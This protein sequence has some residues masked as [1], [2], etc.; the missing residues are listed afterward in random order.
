MPS[1]DVWDVAKERLPGWVYAAV[2]QKAR[3]LNASVIVEKLSDGDMSDGA[4][5]KLTDD[6]LAS[7][8]IRLNQRHVRRRQRGASADGLLGPASRIVDELKRRGVKMNGGL[9]IVTACQGYSRDKEK[10]FKAVPSKDTDTSDKREAQRVRAKKYGISIQESGS[11]LSYPAGSPTVESLYGD[12][13]NLRYPLGREDNRPDLG[14]L[15]N[16]LARF[17]Q[18]GIEGYTDS[19]S[20]AIVFE[21]IVRAALTEGVNV[22]YSPDDPIDALLP[23]GLVSQLV[24]KSKEGPAYVRISKAMPLKRIV[25]GVVLDPYGPNGAK[26]DA[27]NDYISPATIEE[28]AHAF[29]RGQRTIG[30]QHASEADAVLIESSIEQ[31]PPGEYVRAMKGLSHKVYRRPFGDDIVHSGSWIV[32]VQLG[33]KEWDAFEKNE[34]NA[35]SPGG[36][37]I[38]RPITEDEMPEVEFIDLVNGR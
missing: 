31:Y 25:Y 21:R 28:T 5:E 6:E 16:A 27:H 7:S 34:I 20:R 15:R 17:K 19:A 1:K 29:M 23:A 14:R 36:L 32:G 33:E 38:R 4:I 18:F 30:F 9:E 3:Q 37:G 26:A 10:I 13:V 11:N 35:F 2:L 24:E 8:L 12:P 22:G